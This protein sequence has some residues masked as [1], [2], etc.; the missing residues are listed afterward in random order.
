MSGKIATGIKLPQSL[1]RPALAA[2]HNE[3]PL[4]GGP[5]RRYIETLEVFI[6]KD[7]HSARPWSATPVFVWLEERDCGRQPRK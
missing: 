7:R 6:H 5:A 2:R 1:G 4:Q 3:R